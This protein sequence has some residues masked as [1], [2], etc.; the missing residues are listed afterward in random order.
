[1]GDTVMAHADAAALSSSKRDG[2]LLSALFLAYAG[3]SV[4]R[5]AL[6]PSMLDRVM[7]YTSDDGSIIEKIHPTFYG[8]VIVAVVALAT[9][10]ITLTGWE[11][12]V[13]RAIL[14]F[15]GT[16]VGL[17][18]VLAAVGRAGSAGYL[19]DSYLTACC[20]A[21]LFVFPPPWRRVVGS[22]LLSYVVVGAFIGIAE[23]GTK[24][25][26]LPYDALEL[27]FRP[28]GL[29]NHPLEFGLSCATA[30]GFV[31]ASGWS[32]RVRAAAVAVLVLGAFVAG[33][34]LAA[35]VGLASAFALV[36]AGAGA[37]RDPRRALEMRLLAT[38]LAL[39]AVPVVLGVLAG[40][41]A[42]E[43]FQGGLVDESAMA[44][45]NIY[46]V[47]DDLTWGEFLFGS[48]LDRVRQIALERYG[49]KFIESSLVI[50]VVQFGAIGTAIF[51]ALLLNLVRVLLSGAGLAVWIGTVSFL[52]VSASNNGLSTKTS[53]M[54]MLF[55]LT[56]AFRP[57]TGR[58]TAA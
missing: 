51:A 21:L 16:I 52:V 12:R 14:A 40:A 17:L 55:S 27:T 57:A 11:V 45:V 30:I 13:L 47:F 48:D 23:F 26:L 24:S 10:R 18:V 54:F 42:L 38:L 22:L 35:L 33:A 29:S 32:A 50:F 2:V 20:A 5:I 39:A 6:I 3:L 41:G 8:F 15:A 56:I 28:T 25:R 19:I 43:R 37:G 4:L 36:V 58:R 31:A 46:G 9:R 34:R 7:S 1:M 44:R 49:F 53:G